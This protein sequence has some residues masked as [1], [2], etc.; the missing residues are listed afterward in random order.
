MRNRPSSTIF[1]FNSETIIKVICNSFYYIFFF[2]LKHANILPIF[3]AFPQAFFAI[4]F[5]AFF[6]INIST[7]YLCSYKYHHSR[8]WLKH[9]KGKSNELH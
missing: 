5:E 4:L 8:F 9:F 6:Y 2:H 7:N 3:K 1:E